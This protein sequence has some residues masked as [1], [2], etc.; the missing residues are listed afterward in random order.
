MRIKTNTV[1]I[2][3]GDMT[4]MIDMTFQLIAFF[5]VLINFNQTDQTELIQLPESELVRPDEGQKSYTI[6]VNLTS[7]RPDSGLAERIIMGGQE[8]EVDSLGPYLVREVNE[9][10][11]QGKKVS[12]ATVVIRAHRTAAAGKVQE[13]IRICQDHK[14]EKFA[15][16]A[17]EE[18]AP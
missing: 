14:F 11:K 16:R 9:L 12:D 13:V 8:F 5:M 2:S 1:R 10:I 3:E 17:K 6:V 4:P 7:P 18:E 15:L